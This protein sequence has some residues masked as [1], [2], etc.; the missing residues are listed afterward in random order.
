MTKIFTTLTALLV[1]MLAFAQP[2]MPTISTG[3]NEVYYY[4][5]MQRGQAVITSMGNGS[6]VQTATPVASM[7]KRQ[8]WKVIKKG[9]NY[10]I[11]NAAGQTLYYNTSL[12]FFCAGTQPNG[13]QDLKILKTTNKEY[14]GFEISTTGSGKTF[15]NQWGGAGVGYGLGLWVQGDSNNPLQFVAINDMVINDAKPTPIN[16]VSLTG[17]TTWKP[18]NK[19]TLWY[20][21]PATVWMTSTL[22][23]GNGQFGGCVMG[24]VKRDEVQFNDKTLWKGH[25]GA[26]VGNANYGS[27][28]NFGNLYITSTD[29]RLNAATNYRRWL[30]IDQSKAGVAYTANGVDY[31]R[32]YICS[33]PDKVIAIHYKAS[34]KGKISDNIILFNQNGKTPAYDMNGTTGVITF[35]GEVPR[36]GTP[37]GESYYCKAYV[38]AKGGTITVDKDGGIDVKNADEMFIY[39]YG[40][41]NF[42][43]SNDEYISDAAL[44][45][46]HVTGVVDAALRKGYAAICDAHVKDYKAL[47]DR[48]QL[49][50]TTAMPSVTTRKLIGDFA[51]SPA[52]NL[53]LEEIY[54]CYG[55][56]LM[57]SSS[58]GVDLPSNLQGIWNNVNNPAWNSDIHSNI[59]VQMNYW[60][61][62]ITNLSELH[63]PFLKYIH[64]EACERPQWRAN[65]RQIAGQTVGWTLTTENNIYGSGSNWM[66]NYTIANAWYCMHLWQHYRFTL[67]KEYLKNIAYPAM[68]SCAEYWL[69]RLVKAADGTYECPKEFSPEHG[70]GRENATAH[71]QQLVWDLFNNTLQ[72]IAE[73]GISEDA[74]FL[75]DLNNKFKK[76]DT[77]LAIENINGK[78]LLREWKYTSQATVSSYNSHR[79]MSHLMGLYPGN[80]IGQ[81]IDAKIY[82]AAINSL[83]TRGY[84]GTGWSMG[85]KVNLHAR[86]HN[87]NV[88]QTLLKTALH[89]QDNT[90]NSEGGGV[91]ENL[92]DAHTP[93]QI[94]GNFGA[95]AGMAEML[96]QSHLGK[97]DIL[98]A[99]PSMWKNGN[100]K[101]LCAVGDFEVSIEWKNRKAVSIDILSK[102][103]KK[104]VVKYPKIAT[105]FTLIDGQGN[106][107]TATKVSDDEITF[108]TSKGEAYRLTATGPAGIDKT[109][110][111]RGGKGQRIVAAHYYLPN[112]TRVA[113]PSK[114]GLY[115]A[116]LQYE[117]GKKETF[118]FVKYR[119]E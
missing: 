28:L 66:Q 67:D 42:D 108:D 22:P 84:E 116:S 92:W 47:Y 77:G 2:S 43:A 78:P 18:T 29:S 110:A 95:C 106:K 86:A 79:H 111:K 98:P 40:T 68:R 31:Q 69:Q 99:L 104:A 119:S 93:Y 82:Q 15:L 25:V 91:Y 81:E 7:K 35:Q 94:D 27:Y 36:T 102:A 32:E 13:I 55:R 8:T 64:R 70:P 33:F 58:R 73:L 37:K 19:H 96:L 62:E 87:G 38:T 30:D 17:S 10:N 41:T 12:K 20:T 4:I 24:G 59:N 60:P 101:G 90:G 54:F 88:C 75:D 89:F 5:Q 112:G 6:K 9:D 49:N 3:G 72:A 51:I 11:V 76:L 85:W 71:S 118:K 52:D 115:I 114:N 63:L 34:E 105:G 97:L 65:A 1:G 39:L 107:V 46:S 14:Q 103:G 26:V 74:T 50:I 80:Q 109:T 113:A 61:A 117:N 23:I 45:P 48:C 44:L 83:K 56:Y 100:V 53:L 21:K 16:E 57:I